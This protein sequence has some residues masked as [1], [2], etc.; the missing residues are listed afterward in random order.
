MIYHKHLI[1]NAYIECPIYDELKAQE[2]LS[3]LVSEIDMKALIVPVTRYV[4]TPGNRGMTAAVLI[5]TSH[6]AFHIWDEEEP[7]KMRFDLYTCGELDDMFVRQLIDD[8]FRIISCDWWLIDREQG[9]KF[10]DVG[11]YATPEI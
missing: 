4:D 2:F 5:E 6:I 11:N 10:V 7:A 9:I 8:Q 3:N 1:M